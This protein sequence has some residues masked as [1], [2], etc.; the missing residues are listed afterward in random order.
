MET[1]K[2]SGFTIPVFFRLE[3]GRY[4][5]AFAKTLKPDKNGCINVKY[6]SGRKS[7]WLAD[8]TLLEGY[9]HLN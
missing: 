9:K 5:I 8:K 7:K 6:K 2:E 4:K 3:K 1:K